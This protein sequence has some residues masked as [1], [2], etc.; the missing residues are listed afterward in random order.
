MCINEIHGK[1]ILKEKFNLRGILGDKD[2]FIGNLQ[3]PRQQSALSRPQ[4]QKRNKT[5][6]SLK[7]E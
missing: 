6:I 2:V 7:N 1:I 4:T 5:L 3:F